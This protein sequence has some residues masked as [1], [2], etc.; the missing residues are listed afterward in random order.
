M[1]NYAAARALQIRFYPD[2]DLCFDYGYLKREG[3]PEQGWVDSL[4]DYNVVPYQ[5]HA[6]DG[7]IRHEGSFLQKLTGLAYYAGLRKFNRFQM[8]EE[9]QY[10]LDW[11]ERL[12]SAGLYWYRTGYIDLTRSKAKDKLM[13]GRFESPRYFEDIRD[14]LLEEFSPKH[15]PLPANALLYKAAE[16]TNSVCLSVRRGDFESVAK[17]QALHSVCT[18][19]YFLKAIAY[20]KERL[21]NPVFLMFS[22]DIEWVRSNIKIEDCEVH[23]ETGNDPVWEKLRLMS[24][25]KNFIISNSSFSWWSQWLSTNDNKLVVAP[26]RWFNNDFNSPLL[27]DSMIRIEP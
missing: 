7:V 2:E 3:T 21:N 15:D 5:I 13:S 6:K 25:C 1:F 22:D 12:N 17:F 8:S 26:T 19:E 24:S 27:E 18:K 4:V 23:Y 11:S 10:E 14:V 9:Y 20:L 16:S